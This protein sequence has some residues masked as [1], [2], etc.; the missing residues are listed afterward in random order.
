[1]SSLREHIEELRKQVEMFNAGSADEVE[2]LRIRFLSKKGEI[3]S[4][5][6]EFKSVSAD[7]KREVGQML[8]QLKNDT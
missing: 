8:N 5:F 3:T 4:L 2:A 1:M 6:N 7:Q